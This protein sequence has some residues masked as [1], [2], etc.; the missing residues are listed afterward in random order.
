[1]AAVVAI[2]LVVAAVTAVAADARAAVAVVAADPRGANLAGSFGDWRPPHWIFARV[3]RSLSGSFTGAFCSVAGVFRG[4]GAGAV[5]YELPLAGGTGAGVGLYG[6]GWVCLTTKRGH[7]GRITTCF[8][9]FDAGPS[10][11]ARAALGAVL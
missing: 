9:S 10:R 8:G 6:L 2:G 11:H 5:V 7:G 1:V 4:D 3:G